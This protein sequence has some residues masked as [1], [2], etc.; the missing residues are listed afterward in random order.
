VHDQ[1][2]EPK[3]LVFLRAITGDMHSLRTNTEGHKCMSRRKNL[4]PLRAV[5]ETYALKNT[6]LRRKLHQQKQQLRTCIGLTAAT[7]AFPKRL[8][9]TATLSVRH[10]FFRRGTAS[11]P[12]LGR[13]QR[14]LI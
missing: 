13:A 14:A 9:V 3:R 1:K 10:S 12:G 2:Q 11:R 7:G 4:C 6:D 8:R 5:T